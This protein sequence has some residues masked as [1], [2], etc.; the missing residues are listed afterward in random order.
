MGLKQLC[1]ISNIYCFIQSQIQTIVK[2]VKNGIN[3][4]ICFCVLEGVGRV[5]IMSTK[6]KK[7]SSNQEVTTK[8][9]TKK[10]VLSNQ[11][12][13]TNDTHQKSLN[14]EAKVTTYTTD[15]YRLDYFFYQC[16]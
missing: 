13:T 9:A 4:I 6:N 7:L 15:I 5:A 16:R 11:D 10:K 12:T 8:D 3:D 2:V 14:N 1:E